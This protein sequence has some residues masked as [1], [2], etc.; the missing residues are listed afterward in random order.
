MAGLV[1]L[2]GFIFLFV[3]AVC[4]DCYLVAHATVLTVL[5]FVMIMSEIDVCR[6]SKVKIW[7]MIRELKGL[8]V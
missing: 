3:D 5:L 7:V 6:R 4:T 8:G 1:W 2:V